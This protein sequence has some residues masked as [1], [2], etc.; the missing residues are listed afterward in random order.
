MYG[1]TYRQMVH[2]SEWHFK[3]YE[4]MVLCYIHLCLLAVKAM[5]FL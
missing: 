2:I 4:G 1:T 3:K 5:N